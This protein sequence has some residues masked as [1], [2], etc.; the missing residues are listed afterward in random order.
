M[1][2]IS[3][4]S[5]SV[6]STGLDPQLQQL[7]EQEQVAKQE[8]VSRGYPA[9]NT[10]SAEGGAKSDEFEVPVK[11]SHNLDAPKLGSDSPS[12]SVLKEIAVY[13]E[14]ENRFN[15]NPDSVKLGLMVESVLEKGGEEFLDGALARKNPLAGHIDSMQSNREHLASMGYDD[16]LIDGLLAIADPKHPD[17]SLAKMHSLS[18]QI[19]GKLEGD[20][21]L[22][23]LSNL[24]A[25]TLNK[26]AN[27]ESGPADLQAKLQ[28]DL[29]AFTTKFLNSKGNL[30]VDSATI[31]LMQI[32]S[33]LQDNRLKFDQESIK[34][35]QVKQEQASEKRLNKILDSIEKAEKAKDAGLVSKIFG[36]IAV[37]LMA[38]VAAVL[39]VT[40]VFTGGTTA[41]AAAALMVAATALVITMQVSAETGNWMMEIFGDSKKA[42]IAA[43]VF[44]SVLIMCMT[45][46][47]GKLAGAGATAATA[48]QTT[49]TGAN[50]AAGASTGASVTASATTAAT[51]AAKSAKIADMTARFSQ[52]V[53]YAQAGAMIGDGAASAVATTYNYDADMLRAEAKELHAWIL[54]NQHVL[55][56]LTEDIQKVIDELQQGFSTIA[57][58]MK[59]NHETKSKLL[60]SIKG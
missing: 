31:M 53:K 42:K 22:A 37:A 58:I 52:G 23:N 59:D 36:G 2:P 51:A 1:S 20:N 39:V 7:Q 41:I 32:Q 11:A 26:V 10:V 13:T 30:D 43:M 3:S 50:A 54:H 38:I 49:A 57:S 12:E 46:G 4:G 25:D 56:D 34:A 9:E 14:I 48:A 27:L 6:G 33:Q 45:V 55:D 60:G 24:F 8:R 16:D 5:Q 19:T 18:A 17:N 28:A 21:S 47:A 35:N 15:A 40:A 29:K 44:W